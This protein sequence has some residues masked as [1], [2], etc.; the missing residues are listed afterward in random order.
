MRREGGSAGSGDGRPQSEAAQARAKEVTSQ[1]LRQASKHLFAKSGNS[2]P[3]RLAAEVRAAHGSQDMASACTAYRDALGLPEDEG[4]LCLFL[5]SRD[6]A[7][8]RAAL[9]ALLDGEYALE[10]S[11]LRSQLRML[12]YHDDNEVAELA[13]ELLEQLQN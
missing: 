1:Y 4:L 9:Q 11:S 5:D 3:E 8:I 6:D 12:A 2:E 13:E 10:G 7:L